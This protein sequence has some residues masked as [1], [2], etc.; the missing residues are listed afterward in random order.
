MNCEELNN[1]N[2]MSAE[3]KLKISDIDKILH[4]YNISKPSS[5]GMGP[6]QFSDEIVSNGYGQFLFNTKVITKINPSLYAQIQVSLLQE[7]NN[8]K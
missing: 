6:L 1:F 8:K 3:Q 5:C 4:K 2:I 7:C